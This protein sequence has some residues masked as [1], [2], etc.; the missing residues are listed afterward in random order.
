[1]ASIHSACV[2]S[3]ATNLALIECTSAVMIPPESCVLPTPKLM[4]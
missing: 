1:M 2:S 3:P 4:A